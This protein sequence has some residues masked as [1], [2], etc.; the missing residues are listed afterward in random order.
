MFPQDQEFIEYMEKVNGMYLEAGRSGIDPL[1]CGVWAGR[2]T[3][4]RQTMSHAEAMQLHLAEL[5]QGLGL[6]SLGLLHPLQCILAVNADFA[7]TPV[8][9]EHSAWQSYALGGWSSEKRQQAYDLWH[10]LGMTH[11]PLSW[12]LNYPN[13]GVEPFDYRH[14]PDLFA[15]LL[16]ELRHEQFIVWLAA[17]QAETYGRLGPEESAAAILHDLARWPEWGWTGLIE[18]AWVGWES[19]DF[20][21]RRHHLEILRGLR[22]VLGPHKALGVQPGRGLI[23]VGDEAHGREDWWRAM[24]APDIRLD[25]WLFEPDLE[26]FHGEEW[27][28]HLFERMMGASARIYGR[29]R[30]LPDTFPFSPYRTARPFHENWSRSGP[31]DGGGTPLIYWEGPAFLRWSSQ[32]KSEASRVARLVPGVIGQGDGV[33]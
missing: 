27:K 16:E 26:V 33:V 28:E 11:V 32:Q 23:Y 31:M 3:L 18:A 29:L 21:S 17:A 25:A 2:Y 6:A 20:L 15:R 12:A 7:Y 30:E 4:S 5:R 9:G 13:S 1:G 24:H 19:Q 22:E 10:H 8:A 14:H